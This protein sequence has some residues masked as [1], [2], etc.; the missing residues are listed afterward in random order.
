MSLSLM[1]SSFD[2]GRNAPVGIYPGAP[3]ENFAPL[4]TADGSYR[5]IALRR[6]AYASSSH[7]Y[8]LTA[9]LVTDGIVHKTQPPYLTAQTNSGTLPRRER[10]WA[11]DGGEYTR[12]ILMGEKAFI[13][14]RWH[15]MKVSANRVKIVCSMAYSE[16]S[17]GGYAITVSSLTGGKKG[18]ARRTLGKL[19]GK[20]LPGKA[21]KSKAHSDPNKNTDEGPML[22]T[23]NIEAVIDLGTGDVSFDNLKVE[24]SMPGAVHW[25]VTEIKF[26]DGDRAVTDVLPSSQ[27][28][29]AWMSA[30]AGTQWVYVDLGT[31]C[32]FDKVR[33]HWINKARSGRIESSD[34]A[35][36]WKTVAQLPAGNGKTDEVACPGG[37]GRYV[38]VLMLKGATAAPVCA[39]R[40]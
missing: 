14:Y 29:S 18:A 1:L 4:L 38:R 40:A 32:E 26:F 24:L 31:Q 34:D 3:G 33:L 5:N 10:E 37:K 30:K 11:I 13:S 6:M 16:R 39:Q 7:D 2:D 9:Q 21:S 15:N 36:N 8:N 17:K 12:N 23:R 27:F 22:P 19:T 35:R 28:G 20:G 25:T